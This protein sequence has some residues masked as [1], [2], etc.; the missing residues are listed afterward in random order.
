[1]QVI[2]YP[3]RLVE[4]D[5]ADNF[6]FN[7]WELVACQYANEWPEYNGRNRNNATWV[8]TFCCS[9]QIRV[10]NSPRGRWLRHS[11]CYPILFYNT[12]EVRNFPG[13][14]SPQNK[15]RYLSD[16]T[17]SRRNSFSICCRPYEL[18]SNLIGKNL[19]PVYTLKTST[20]NKKQH[21]REKMD[22]RRWKWN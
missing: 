5:D 22:W 21:A 19:S 7:C 1:M 2:L 20:P 4:Y 9:V 18:R 16:H 12:L 10:R 11:F 17:R 3:Y 14:F 15:F 8:S 6:F 13:R